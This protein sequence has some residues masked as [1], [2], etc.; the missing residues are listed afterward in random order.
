[1]I[2]TTCRRIFWAS[3]SRTSMQLQCI[4][5]LN[6]QRKLLLMT[7]WECNISTCSLEFL[8]RRYA[9]HVHRLDHT[10]QVVV[11]SLDDG[12]RTK[13][14]DFIRRLY[15][16]F[17]SQK[18]WKLTWFWLLQTLA[19]VYA[20]LRCPCWWILTNTTKC[21]AIFNSFFVEFHAQLLFKIALF[22]LNFLNSTCATFNR[23][24]TFIKISQLWPRYFY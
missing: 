7:P 13:A 14:V 4:N 16:Q 8:K 6:G 18:F 24:T 17:T 12:R 5:F 9:I 10:C 15:K 3:I 22:L 1:M 20:D 19:T 21:S 11:S 23:C 2:I